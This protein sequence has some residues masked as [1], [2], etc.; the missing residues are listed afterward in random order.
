MAKNTGLA[1]DGLEKQDAHGVHG[2]EC[3]KSRN[4]KTN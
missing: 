2:K 1:M 3:A 4:I